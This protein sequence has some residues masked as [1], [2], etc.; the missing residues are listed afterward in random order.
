MSISQNFPSSR[1]SLNLNFARSK[2]LDPR[3]TFTRSSTATFVDEDG[4]VKRVATDTTRFE[5][6]PSTGESL[7][8]LIEESR[9]NLVTYSEQFDNAAWTKTN[10][11]ITTNTS[12]TTAPDGN[13]TAE[14]LVEN[15]ASNVAHFAL[16]TVS[17][18]AGSTYTFSVFVKAAE[19]T[20][21]Q[22]G[23]LNANSPF[24]NLISYV[25][26][27]NGSINSS[28]FGTVTGASVSTISYP[29][30]WYRIILTGVIGSTTSL[31]GVIWPATSGAVDAAART[32]TGDG[33]SGI[34]IWGGQ[35]EAGAFPTS[36]IPTVASTVTRSA[37]S[38]S[39]TGANFSNWYNPNE[40]TMFVQGAPSTN[41]AYTGWL[42][43]IGSDFNNSIQTYRQ[44]DYQP[45]VR[46]R[47]SGADVYGAVGFGA[48]WTTNIARKIILTFKT[49]SFNSAVS[50][51]VSSDVTSGTLPSY[52][53]LSIGSLASTNYF[54]GTI[55]QLIYYP[56]RLPNATLQSLT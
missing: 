55:S 46:I 33:T 36:Y 34:Y 41:A 1:P 7:G 56:V 51:T 5:H 35:L 10:A 52:S 24:D 50:G 29:N 9:S 19:R 48:I 21:V 37:D 16:Q 4:L 45:V 44:S 6:T 27:T 22:V 12:A 26:L 18:T 42:Y 54:N 30:G 32:Y 20:F 13:T 53:N 3:I 8:L 40:G 43:S 47:S 25:N 17:A 14:K 49:N 31:Q 23:L 11:G 15:T 39:I 2:K 28:T 38:A